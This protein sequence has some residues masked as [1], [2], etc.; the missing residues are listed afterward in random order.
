ML[1]KA[2]EP[3]ELFVE[4]PIPVVKKIKQCKFKLGEDWASSFRC[5]RD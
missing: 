5:L 2:F 4:E 1:R 3:F